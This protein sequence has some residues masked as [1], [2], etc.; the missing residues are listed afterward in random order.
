MLHS[1]P[2]SA[3]PAIQEVTRYMAGQGWQPLPRGQYWY[4]YRFRR[5]VAR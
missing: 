3:G 1:A 5:D 4:S 2:G